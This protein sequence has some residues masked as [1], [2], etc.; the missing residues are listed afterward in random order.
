MG[1]R[2]YA[3][4]GLGLLLA[5]VLVTS[6]TP[7]SAGQAAQSDTTQGGVAQQV[8]GQQL[9]A[10]TGAGASTQA[11]AQTKAAEAPATG[12][13][14]SAGS[15]GPAAPVTPAAPAVEKTQPEPQV[16]PEPTP[17]PAE[18]QQ[19]TDPVSEPATDPAAVPTQTAPP[20]S[21]T[22]DAT[23]PAPEQQ[24]LVAEPAD[25][26]VEDAASTK[27]LTT[28]ASDEKDSGEIVVK[29]YK[30]VTNADGDIATAVP[31]ADW[32]FSLVD[33][34][35]SIKNV[36]DT[37]TT[38]STGL[39]VFTGNTPGNSPGAN[40]NI[41]ESAPGLSDYQV[42]QQGGKN[43]VC[44]ADDQNINVEDQGEFGFSIRASADDPVT[45]TIYNRPLDTAKLTLVNNVKTGMA[46]EPASASEWE[47][48]AAPEAASAGGVT[49]PGSATG[50]SA[51]VAP[52]TYELSQSTGPDNYT[53]LS[54][55]CSTDGGPI[56]DVEDF[57]IDLNVDTE[58]TCTFTNAYQ[59]IKIEKDPWDDYLVPLGAAATWTYTVKNT[60]AT[61]I[62]DITVE[63]EHATSVICKKSQLEPGET[64]TCTASGL[65]TS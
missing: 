54:L 4:S 28:K 39:A 65:L 53:W 44:T 40:L 20:A 15:G 14:K 26:N 61:D 32:E 56:V 27:D 36:N 34:G 41:E 10:Q 51:D 50:Q 12:S 6:A 60:G 62:H 33:K 19:S 52:G 1:T 13:A 25:T 42:V 57:S 24:N 5:F 31:K 48:T 47:L 43:A 29:V 64:M 55:K 49:V 38:N 16:K 18:P 59:A 23:Q 63:D 11:S 2:R 7:A 22:E 45:C 58:T 21:G 17:A 46:D 35:S 30:M 8:G 9:A 37:A 3:K